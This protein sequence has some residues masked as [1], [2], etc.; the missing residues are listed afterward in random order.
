MRKKII[1]LFM[2]VCLTM[3]IFLGPIN[4]YGVAIA[5][6][7][8][9]LSNENTQNL[10]ENEHQQEVVAES[11]KEVENE[12]SQIPILN[13]ETN[14]QLNMIWVSADGVETDHLSET[15]TQEYWKGRLRIRG[16]ISTNERSEYQYIIDMGSDF[17][18]TLSSKNPEI[19]VHNLPQTGQWEISSSR[20]SSEATEYLEEIDVV[21]E[22]P[23][24]D[25][26][27]NSLDFNSIN[28]I[29][30]GNDEVSKLALSLTIP[31][32]NPDL[33]KIPEL[34]PDKQETPP[35]A[36]ESKSVQNSNLL[37][38]NLSVSEV[39]S[40]PNP[41]AGEYFDMTVRVNSGSIGDSQ[42]QIKHTKIAV[43]LPDTI[44]IISLPESNNYQITTEQVGLDKRITI[45]YLKELPVGKMLAVPFGLRFKKGI[46]LPAT[47]LTGR[48]NVTASNANGKEKALDG[49][50]PKI[51]EPVSHLIAEKDPDAEP[52]EIHTS[53]IKIV[54]ESEI[55]GVNIK[56]GNLRIEFPAEI[57]LYSVT[58]K[59]TNYPVEG[60]KNGIYS[61]DIPVGDINVENAETTVE[62]TYEYPYSTTG[63]PKIHEIKARLTGKRLDGTLVNEEVLLPETVPAVGDLS[64]YPGIKFFTKIAPNKVLKEKDQTLAYTLSF[65]PKL[66]MRDV[67]LVDDP[68]RSTDELDFFEGFRYQS[69][70]WS[71]QKSKNPAIT[72]LVSTE[73]FYQTKNDNNWHSMGAASPANTIQVSSLGLS[74]GD[75]IT[76]VKYKFTYQGSNKL[77][78]DA[79]KVSISAIGKTMEGVKDATLS[80]ADGLTN[81]LYIYGDRKH[82]NAPDSSY[83][84]FVQGGYEAN[85]DNK[86]NTQ[87]ATT[88]LTGEGAFPGYYEWG[89]PFSPSVNDI[90]D[91]FIYQIGVNNVYGSGALKDAILFITV[92]TSINIE[93]VELVNPQNDPN[94]QIEIKQIGNSLQLVT[95]R[96]NNNWLNNEG[97]NNN[98]AI[99]ITANGSERVKGVE[100]FSNY[101]VSGDPKQN[102]DDG[103]AWTAV[104]GAGSF[105]AARSQ[106]LPVNFNRS[107]GLD[108]KK[109]I[110]SNGVDFSRVINLLNQGVGNDVTYRITV[111]NNGDIKINELHVIDN[112]PSNNDTMTISGDG[113]HSTIG[114][115]LKSISLAD[116]SLLS[117]NYELYYS[118]NTNAENNLTELK[119]LT[120][121]QSTWQIWDG[122][123]PLDPSASAIK[124][125]KKDGLDAKQSV[126]FH[127]S[128]H[129]PETASELS[130]L[131]NSFAVGGSYVDGAT[132]PTLEV[133]EPVKSGAYV[134]QEEPTKQI[135]GI[136][137]LDENANG[138]REESEARIPDAEVALYDWNNDLVATTKTKADGSYAFNQLYNKKYHVIIKRVNSTF[139]LTSYQ[140]GSEKTINNDFLEIDGDEQYGEA[141]VDLATEEKPLNI[142]GGYIE[143]TTIDGYIWYDS[144]RDGR[145]T[146]GEAPAS[147]VTVSLYRVENTRQETFVKTVK[148]GTNGKYFFTGSKIVPGNYVIHAEIPTDYATTIKGQATEKQVSKF[149]RNGKTDII[150]VKKGI[151]S[152]W[153]LGLVLD[154][155]TYTKI[156]GK[157]IWKE[158][159]TKKSQ[160]PQSIKIQVF[161]DGKT[162]GKPLKVS[163][164]QTDEWTFLVDGLPEYRPQSDQKYVYTIK[165]VDIPV[166]YTSKV[167]DATFTITNTYTA[168]ST[169]KD[170]ESSKPKEQT[171]ESTK[172]PTS[173]H[174]G[175]SETIADPNDRNI[176]T[177]SSYTKDKNVGASGPPKNKLPKTGEQIQNHIFLGIVLIAGSIGFTLMHRK[178]YGEF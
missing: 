39:Y 11:D 33:I 1:N 2:L 26:Q 89:A 172:E 118:T 157:K 85:Q 156:E 106:N 46:S 127:L 61:V 13:T 105:S 59:G 12:D 146:A 76:T 78:K 25:S 73:L 58:Y 171:S 170:P 34:K 126:S 109:E 110:S 176:V 9:G 139:N 96:Y 137:W 45:N 95:I 53:K 18:G 15:F 103:V 121:D 173:G 131:W 94:A 66:D 52:I 111:P 70:S 67:Y 8:I 125:I 132:K 124:I 114:G 50:H 100:K 29:Y 65:S 84:P 134:A 55:G 91:T 169:E 163:S 64:G 37:V 80:L 122:Q 40:N 130:T 148:T 47:T 98:H 7:E 142:D 116:G 143:P 86:N 97:W 104:P 113:R 93:N 178:K 177:S 115:Q 10:L 36:I 119:N 158:D 162:Y 62:L 49:I 102:Y 160:R 167:D 174:T 152:D 23:N 101:L 54:P 155:P 164:N 22:K 81:T 129:V 128:Y 136:L 141:V 165:E 108:S 74:S 27:K 51:K 120:N 3:P 31:T 21:I 42:E 92:P 71:A 168:N 87:T 145:Q 99:R 56:N 57:E 138:L 144:D 30:E 5:A 149:N 4:A 44:E 135:A 24:I 107:V 83:E 43:T 151:N 150:E 28:L 19:S 88:L 140:T 147:N 17:N 16:N 82:A 166:N 175:S 117:E 75:Y 32:E 38:A 161:Q 60:P 90:G 77:P 153:D 123:T 133:G 159:Q 14:H 41:L 48:I 6:E 154:L 35:A 68:I 69:F 20:L 63:K 72:G 79:G 112:L